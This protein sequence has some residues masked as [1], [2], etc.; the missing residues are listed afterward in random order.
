MEARKAKIIKAIRDNEKAKEAIR[1]MA[2]LEEQPTKCFNCGKE[3]SEQVL[4]SPE[5]PTGSQCC[6][7]YEADL[8]DHNV[9]PRAEC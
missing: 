3:F 6:S 8:I 2:G 9:S 4:C 5:D 1:R 7:C